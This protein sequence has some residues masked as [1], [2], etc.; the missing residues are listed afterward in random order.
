MHFFDVD[1]NTFRA[2]VISLTG[3]FERF[4]VPTLSK[5]P[6]LPKVVLG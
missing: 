3:Y 1:A 6:T 5:F 4:I 2:L